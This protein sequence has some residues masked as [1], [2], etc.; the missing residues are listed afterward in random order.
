MSKRNRGSKFPKVIVRS[1]G[2]EPVLLV[3]YGTEKYRVI[4]G[5]DQ[6]RHHISLPMGEVFT[7]DEKV[8]SDLRSAY[9]TGDR[10]RLSE[11]YD[12]LSEDKNICNRYKYM[13]ELGHDEEGQVTD[14]TGVAASHSQ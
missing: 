13:L 8:Y 11:I 14:F 6:S 4:V 1:W 7:F 12:S 5:S 10:E 3:A 2:N 9:D